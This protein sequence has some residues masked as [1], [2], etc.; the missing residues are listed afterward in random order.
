MALN[1]KKEDSLDSVVSGLPLPPKTLAGFLLAVAAVL[2]VALISYRSLQAN[3]ASARNLAESIEANVVHGSDAPETAAHE[4]AF[5]FSA[6]E[7]CPR[8]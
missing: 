6:T 3:V 7:I 5:F 4:I 1:S 8:P 2:L